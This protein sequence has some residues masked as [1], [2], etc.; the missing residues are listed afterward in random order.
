MLRVVDTEPL[1]AARRLSGQLHTLEFAPQVANVY[2]PLR[3]AWAPYEAY[4][5]RYGARRA[6]ARCPWA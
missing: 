1:R 6:G 3:Y 5:R 2:D 4:V